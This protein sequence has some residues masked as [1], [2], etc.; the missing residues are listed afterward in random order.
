VQIQA[1]QHTS[2]HEKAIK[3]S[4]EQTRLLWNHA[5]VTCT[6]FKNVVNYCCTLQTDTTVVRCAYL[7]ENL[8]SQKFKCLHILQHASKNNNSRQVLQLTWKSNVD[9]G[10][11]SSL[12][13]I[14][15]T[16]HTTASHMM[17]AVGNAALRST[18]N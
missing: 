16:H 6:L 15:T 12:P 2:A 5:T 1:K 9:K 13:I 17:I 14:K 4:E 11:V 3:G 8:R 10:T 7:Q 18:T